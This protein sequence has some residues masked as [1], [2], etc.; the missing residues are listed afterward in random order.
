MAEQLFGLS[1]NHLDAN[2]KKTERFLLD[3]KKIGFDYYE[4][5]VTNYSLLANYHWIKK[6]KDDFIKMLNSI[7][8]QYSIHLPLFIDLGDTRTNYDDMF[9]SFVEFSN[10]ANI[11][12]LILHPTRIRNF[13]ATEV[14]IGNLKRLIPLLKESGITIHLENLLNYKHHNGGYNYNVSLND[15]IQILSKLNSDVYGYCFDC[16]HGYL[17]TKFREENFVEEV[18][19]IM[20]S[21]TYLHVHDNFG[22]I[23]EMGKTLTKHE[24]TMM[25]YGDLH[26]PPSWGEIPYDELKPTFKNY[27]GRI[28]VELFKDYL[29]DLDDILESTK[30]IF[31]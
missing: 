23:P 15:N 22:K 16:G 28:T 24:S 18:N 7:P 26:M 8:L 3:I 14:E 13:G 27:S 1:S 2:F 5:E 21:I 11:K 29:N 4:L 20:S 17:T 6:R 10:E 12:D 31:I 30:E 19:D 9:K 25:G